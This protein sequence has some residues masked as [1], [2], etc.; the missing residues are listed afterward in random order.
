M[1]ESRP[2]VPGTPK[3]RKP[4]GYGSETWVER[5]GR[6]YDLVVDGSTPR[7]GSYWRRRLPGAE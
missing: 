6:E 1:K 2:R 3:R 4:R 5:Q 7:P